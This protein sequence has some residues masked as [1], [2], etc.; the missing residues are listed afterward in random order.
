MKWGDE[1]LQEEVNDHKAQRN[2]GFFV[3]VEILS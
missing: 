2:P 3:I 1:G